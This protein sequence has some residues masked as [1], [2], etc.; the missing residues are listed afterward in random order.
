MGFGTTYLALLPTARR[1]SSDGYVTVL[2]SAAR[3]LCVKQLLALDVAFTYLTPFFAC[4]HHRS[5]Q[6]AASMQV[7]QIRSNGRVPAVLHRVVDA[8]PVDGRV[9]RRNTATL[10]V[11]PTHVNTHVE[12]GAHDFVA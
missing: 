5:L 7:T 10:F 3:A 6:T 12:P 8:D 11:A 1:S 4:L 2:I 9:R